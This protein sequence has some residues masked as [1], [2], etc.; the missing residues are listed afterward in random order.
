M[1]GSAG[2]EETS[3]FKKIVDAVNWNTFVIQCTHN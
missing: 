3:D 2:C 1:Q